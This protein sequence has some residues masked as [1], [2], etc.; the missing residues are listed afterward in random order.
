VGWLVGPGGCL[1]EDLQPGYEV[2]RLTRRHPGKG[3]REQVKAEH[4]T[5]P[6]SARCPAGVSQI[7]VRRR[8]AGSLSRSSSPWS[9]RWLTISLMTD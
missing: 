2:I 8:S 7:S 6:R 5:V 9:S 1:D 4:L 3:P